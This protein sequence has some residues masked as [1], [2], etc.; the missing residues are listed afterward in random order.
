MVQMSYI[1][2]R[3]FRWSIKID[4]QILSNAFIYTLLF[5]Q[6]FPAFFYTNQNHYSPITR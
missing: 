4:D 3:G 2:A 5:W 1:A 6:A